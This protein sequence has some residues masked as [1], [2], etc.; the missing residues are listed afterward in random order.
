ML[1][2]SVSIDVITGFLG[3]GKTTLLRHILDRGLGGRRVA[4]IVNEIGE[5]GVDGRVLEGVNVERMIELDS[6]CVCCTISRHFGLA[7]QELVETV[8][9][10]LI[11]VETTGVADPSSIAYEAKQVGFPLDAT[12][13]VV[14]ALDF[15]RHAGA[16]DV[17]REQVAAADFVVLNKTDLV[18][19]ERVARVESAIRAIN[20][21]ALVV[22]THHGAVD[23]DVLFGTSARSHL[24]RL[25]EE[26]QE[27]GS[28]GRNHA[29]L[30]RDEVSAFVY[31]AERPFVR[32]RFEEFLSALPTKVYRAKGLVRFTDSEWSALFNFTCGRSEFE[33]REPVGSD[34]VGRAV[35]IGAGIEALRHGLSRELD[36]C[37]VRPS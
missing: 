25:R 9:P 30:D 32:S 16:S 5:V 20:N 17:T 21:R 6:G 26:G 27:R 8:D 36:A 2:E 7:L 1:P 23:P 14:D 31:T 34:F 28:R 12:I 18:D 13:T 37:M 11:V 19:D 24:D 4:V 29:H 35:F 33:W 22:R 3:S 10:E 15:E